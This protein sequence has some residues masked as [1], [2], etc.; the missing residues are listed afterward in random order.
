MNLL[1]IITSTDG[2]VTRA[3]T[4]F[5]TLEEALSALYY[6]MWY[7]ASNEST[8]AVVCEIISDEGHIAKCE[9]FER[10]VQPV[11]EIEGEE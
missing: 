5:A 10:A 2:N 8:Q 7:A 9:R 6:E 1:K 3:L 11:E 4:N